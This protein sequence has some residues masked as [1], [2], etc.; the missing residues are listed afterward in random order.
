MAAL[1]DLTLDVY[2]MVYGV[3]QVTRPV[4]DT[5]STQVT[6]GAD[7]E[8]RFTTPA[9]WKRGDYAEYWPGDGT[10]GEMVLLTEDHPAAAD[11]T[12]RRGQRRTTAVTGGFAAGA[13]FLKNP[14]VPS[15]LVRR[16]ITETIDNDLGPECFYRVDDSL[17]PAAGT[18][19]YAL[20]DRDFYIEKVY[21]YDLGS[22]T[23]LNPFPRGWYEIETNLDTGMV[24][25]GVAMRLARWYDTTEDVYYT[26][27][28]QPAVEDIASFPTELLDLIPWGAAA[29]LFAMAAPPQRIDPTRGLQVAQGV[30]ANQPFADATYFRQEFERMK[31][32]YRRFLLR[33]MP[34]QPA[35]RRG[36]QQVWRG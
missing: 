23:N 29:R 36:P 25:S 12:V 17:T 31:N 22:Q 4:E 6:D 2:D 11:V 28:R 9:L 10:E 1:D 26:T 14:P 3:G 24:A 18:R 13:V 7:V 16:A 32:Q 34:P 21:Q 5:L 20:D 27:R 33:Q 19:Y 8:W 15:V 30:S 35:Y